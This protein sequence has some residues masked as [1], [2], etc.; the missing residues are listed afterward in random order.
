VK[1]GDVIVILADKGD[2]G[3]TAIVHSVRRS[4]LRVIIELPKGSQRLCVLRK[5]D[6]LPEDR[7]R[8]AQNLERRLIQSPA[9]A[10]YDHSAS[11]SPIRSRPSNTA[12]HMTTIIY[13]LTVTYPQDGPCAGTT[14]L[15]AYTHQV[16]ALDMLERMKANN[17]T[18][19]RI[20]SI[21][22]VELETFEP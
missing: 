13:V 22:E 6:C 15:R 2:A 10:E 20:F 14:N 12:G 11:P 9:M 17:P 21:Q 7:F 5:W 18:P 16:V 3:L 1:A 4:C 19:K 8:A